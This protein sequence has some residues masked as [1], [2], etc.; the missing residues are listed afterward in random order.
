MSA[1]DLVL[2]SACLA[3]LPT[4]YDGRLVEHAACLAELA[5]VV[6]IPVCPE[7]LGGLPTPRSPADIVGGNGHD[8]L[9]GRA[10]V[11][12]RDGEDVT[13]QFIRGA[14]QVLDIAVR[15]QVKK[16]LLKAR[17]PS[18]G[19]AKTGVTAALLIR[20]GFEVAEFG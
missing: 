3:G 9:D 19:V 17:S 1:P 6:W 2:V 10:R 13:A 14:E 4:R 12:C 8:V 11:I 20:H 5:G 18:C 7:Q 16:V 15:H